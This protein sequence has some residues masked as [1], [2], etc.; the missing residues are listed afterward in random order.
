MKLFTTIFALVCAVVCFAADVKFD[1][2]AYKAFKTATERS[3]YLK[4]CTVFDKEYAGFQNSRAAM[5]ANVYFREKDAPFTFDEYVAKIKE[6]ASPSYEANES[7]KYAYI[8]IVSMMKGYNIDTMIK[9]IEANLTDSNLKRA[10]S[11]VGARYMNNRFGLAKNIDKAIEYYKK[12]EEFGLGGLF[13][14]YYQ[15]RDKENAW[16]TGVVYLLD[17]YRTPAQALKTVKD[18]FNRKPANIKNED[19]VNFIKELA[20]KY[21]T[22]GSNFD[23]WKGFMGFIG[24]KYKAIT[25]K[26]L[27]NEGSAPAAK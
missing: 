24:Y 16:K 20:D 18:M 2:E 12:A 3:N 14:C 22:P 4:S 8:N 10:Y 6:A 17:D 23:D 9:Y 13:N 27:F 11:I 5:L 25:G 21:P 7:T 26:D 15:K 19:I 1:A